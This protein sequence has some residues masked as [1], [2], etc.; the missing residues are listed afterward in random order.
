MTEKRGIGFWVLISLSSLLAFFLIIGQTFS[1]INYEQAVALGLQESIDEIGET[2]IVWAK[3]FAFGDTV[4]YIPLLIAGIIGLLKEK[5]WGSYAMFGSLAVTVYW[6]IVHLYFIYAG[7]GVIDLSPDK[8]LSYSII[9]P[10]LV[11]YSLWG[12][13]FLLKHK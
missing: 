7:R 10:L 6:P 8:Y 2:G 11:I 1:L 9:L 3:S 13:W 5:K 4:F 12:M